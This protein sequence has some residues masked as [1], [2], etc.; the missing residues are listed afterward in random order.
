MTMI[1]TQKWLAVLSIGAAL[2]NPAQAGDQMDEFAW[3][4]RPVIVFAASDNDPVAIDQLTRLEAEREA[5]QDRDMVVIALWPDRSEVDGQTSALSPSG[6][7]ARYSIAAETFAILLV[8]KD[9]GV[10]RESSKPLDPQELFAQVDGMPMRR[11]EMQ[12]RSSQ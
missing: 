7:R 10:K 9:T 8:R 3:S 5:L 6:L 2:T 1:R 4:A 11:R 12:Q